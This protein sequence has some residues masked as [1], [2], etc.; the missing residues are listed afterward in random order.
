MPAL[1]LIFPVFLL[2][3]G[4]FFML[5][6]KS[7]MAYV[8]L[9]MVIY[10]ML[11]YIFRV[12]INLWW[13]KKNPPKLD[14]EMAAVLAKT[15]PYYHNLNKKER[16]RFGGRMGV[17]EIDKE[18]LS[19]EM[20]QIPEEI[21]GLTL[22]NAVQITFGLKDFLLEE[23]GILVFYRQQF[24]TPKIQEF[25]A[26][27]VDIADGCLIIA[28][29]PMIKG[30]RYPHKSYNMALHQFALFLQDQMKIGLDD[31]IKLDQPIADRDGYFIA[32]L[33]EIRRWTDNFEKFYAP[34]PK[35]EYF[36]VAVEH[37]FNAPQRF[38]EVLPKS[39]LAMSNLLNQ[40]PLTPNNP[41]IN[42]KGLEV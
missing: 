9:P 10:I 42:H 22:A 18:Y 17:F 30:I 32:K 41:V 34:L 11:V 28:T 25:H 8:L 23:L 35:E 19:K 31:F 39:F 38:R 7:M 14:P 2:A 27:E 29:D 15:F 5:E 21:K 33:S 1:V 3:S 13:Y 24:H 36:G 16:R 37:F 26:G 40:N 20:P 12:Q 6:D 4:V